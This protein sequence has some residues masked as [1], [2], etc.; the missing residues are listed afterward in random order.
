MR[1]VLQIFITRILHKLFELNFIS[2]YTKGSLWA[3]VV[4]IHCAFVFFSVV[5]FVLLSLRCVCFVLFTFERECLSLC[6]CMYGSTYTPHIS[7]HTYGFM[8]TECVTA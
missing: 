4:F 5:F 8:N 2:K 1:S 7:L 6:Q 3:M